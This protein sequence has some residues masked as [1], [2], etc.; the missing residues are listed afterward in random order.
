MTALIAENGFHQRQRAVGDDLLF[1]QT[2][3]HQQ[4]PA[5]DVIQIKAVRL[6]QLA[7]KLVKARDRALNELREEGDEQRKLRRVLFRRVFGVVDVDEIAHGL[8]RV[9]A[10][11][12]RQNQ[13]QRRGILARQRRAPCHHGIQIFEHGQH[14]EVEQQHREKPDSLRG[15]RLCFARLF[16]LGGQFGLVFVQIS[17]AAF[18]DPADFQ[19]ARPRRQ[20]RNQD[21][22]QREHATGQIEA[23]AQQEQQH[24][25][26]AQR[27]DVIQ[28]RADEG[29]GQQDRKRH[30]IFLFSIV[31]HWKR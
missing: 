2:P 5:L 22:R 13:P 4:Q 18:A 6:N 17:F 20:R 28:R 29:D 11:A 30:R 24:P 21:E 7:F 26:K 12:Q 3:E 27:T 8:E 19:R 9:K 1:E 31:L 25:S 23:V 16:L 14:A 15:T 10:D